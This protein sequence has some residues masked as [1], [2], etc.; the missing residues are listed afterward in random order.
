MSCA[1]FHFTQGSPKREEGVIWEGVL[2]GDHCIIH[3]NN[4]VIDSIKIYSS[5]LTFHYDP[6]VF[7]S[8]ACSVGT[9]YSQTTFQGGP[10]PDWLEEEIKL[11]KALRELKK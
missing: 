6:Q 8:F 3:G 10:F 1:A 7:F 9:L 4:Q 5:P 11:R 2:A